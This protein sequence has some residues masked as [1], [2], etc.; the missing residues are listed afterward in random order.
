M[1]IVKGKRHISEVEMR[2]REVPKNTRY[3]SKIL[4]RLSAGK[5][6]DY[7]LRSEWKQWNGCWDGRRLNKTEGR[8]Q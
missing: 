8:R 6:G 7:S 1:G 5:Q 3:F 4:H 2:R